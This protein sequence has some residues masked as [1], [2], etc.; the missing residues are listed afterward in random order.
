MKKTISLLLSLVMIFATLATGGLASAE[1]AQTATVTPSEMY[2]TVYNGSTYS[3]TMQTCY[4]RVTFAKF[5]FTGLREQLQNATKMYVHLKTMYSEATFG[6]FRIVALKQEHETHIS[7][8]MTYSSA[9]SL[10]AVG[11]V[12]YQ[13]YRVDGVEHVGE[14]AMAIEIDKTNLINAL[15]TGNDDILGLRFDRFDWGGA[16]TQFYPNELK[17]TFE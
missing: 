16:N 6:N 3:N 9:D 10:G 12:T 2:L 5:D 15:N 1:A 17:I 4:E 13:L 14:K 11:D 7:S 8:G